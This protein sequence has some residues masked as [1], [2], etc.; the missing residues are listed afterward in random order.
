[1]KY[2]YN[3]DIVNKIFTETE[4]LRDTLLSFHGIG[5][6]TADVLLLYVF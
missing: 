4:T 5:E 1:M 6:E 3:P 2:Q